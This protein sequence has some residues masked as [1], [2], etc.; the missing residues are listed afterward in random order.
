MVSF[1]TSKAVSDGF[2]QFSVFMIVTDGCLV[3]DAEMA[4]CGGIRT[5]FDE[6][7]GCDVPLGDIETTVTGLAVT[8]GEMTVDGN[9]LGVSGFIKGVTDNSHLPGKV[10]EE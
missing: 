4:V 8:N 3:C 5:A 9:V 7:N 10:T 6:T 2:W 1:K